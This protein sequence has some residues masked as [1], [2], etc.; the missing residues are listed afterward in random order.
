LKILDLGRARLQ[1]RG[2]GELATTITGSNTIMMGTVD[3]MAPEQ[4]LDSHVVDIR[5]DIYSL[6][7]TLFYLL[8]GQPPFPGGTEA[9]KLVRHQMK[10]PPDVRQ[11]RPEVPQDLAAILAKMLVKEPGQRFQTPAQVVLALSGAAPVTAM[12]PADTQVPP[13]VPV[14]R[15][16]A[17]QPPADTSIVRDPPE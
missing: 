1:Q 10:P 7:C 16:V 14:A 3:Y 2:T 11:L 8:T 5:A 12:P 17:A 15:V 4:A 6:G 9:E 13:A